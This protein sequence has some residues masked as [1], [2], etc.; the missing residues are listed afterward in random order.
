[1]TGNVHVCTNSPINDEVYLSSFYDY[2]LYN[3]MLYG[4]LTDRMS[5]SH[6]IYVNWL[7]QRFETSGFHEITRE[8]R[9]L[10]CEKLFGEAGL[11]TNTKSMFITTTVLPNLRKTIS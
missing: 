5:P 4:T 6:R 9:L 11:T 7:I 3:S 10:L 2:E 1:M 8:G